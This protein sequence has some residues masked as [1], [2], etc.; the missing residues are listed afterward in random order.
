MEPSAYIVA[1][2]SLSSLMTVAIS[3]IRCLCDQSGNCT[4]GCLETPLLKDEHE[5]EVHEYTLGGKQY[6]IITAKINDASP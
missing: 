6:L 3:R 4:T 2:T 1:I 5:M